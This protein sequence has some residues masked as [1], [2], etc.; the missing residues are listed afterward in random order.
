MNE[1][2]FY[3]NH[4]VDVNHRADKTKLSDAEKIAMCEVLMDTC[5]AYDIPLNN[6]ED[7]ENFWMLIRY[8]YTKQERDKDIKTK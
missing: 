1:N 5:A 4:D 7:A 3:L 6:L 2:S 8:G